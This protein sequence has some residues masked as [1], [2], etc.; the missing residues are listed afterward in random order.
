MTALRAV[1]IGFCAVCLTAGPSFCDVSRVVAEGSDYMVI[2]DEAAPYPL[3]ARDIDI[4]EALR[5]F[6]RNLRIGL[7]V[8]GDISGTVTDRGEGILSRRE[9]LDTRA[10]EF[11]FVW[12]F[13]GQVL[14]VSPVGEIETR[15]IPLRENSGI[16][17]LRIL[18]SLGIYQ[19]KFT[20]R[21]DERSR[22]LMVAGP[23][24]Y[25]ELIDQATK[26]LETADRTD[27]TLLRGNEG[28]TPAALEALKAST[29]AAEAAEQ[30]TPTSPAE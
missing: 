2:P 15:I 20:H 27:I 16:E 22:T 3:I 5:V 24:G 26:A 21:Y 18:Q 29:E 17:A 4:D 12:Y 10:A 11:D 7:V 25:V 6:A 23:A 13:D 14:R 9:Y 28:G 30:T 1:V 19:R 8:T